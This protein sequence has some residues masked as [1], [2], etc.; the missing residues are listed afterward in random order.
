M[1]NHEIKEL[2][3]DVLAELEENPLARHEELSGCFRIAGPV[4]L[5]YS[6]SGG[7]VEVKLYFDKIRVAS[8]KVCVGEC[9][10][11]SGSLVCVKGSV[12]VCLEQRGRD[13][14]LTYK[15]KACTRSFPCI[16]QSWKCSSASG[17]IVCV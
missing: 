7:C 9:Q 3:G 13:L 1:G 6:F 16:G 12:T 8:A 15:A 5:C 2:E 17:T 11:L 14:C 10:T 4:K